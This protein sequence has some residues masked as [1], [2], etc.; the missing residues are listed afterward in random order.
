[1]SE[2]DKTNLYFIK[3]YDWFIN[4]DEIR[5]IESQEHGA[6]VVLM[7]FRLMIIA[8]N[9]NGKIARI[10]GK[11]ETPYTI[12]EMASV[13]FKTEEQLLNGLEI[14]KKAE[15]VFKEDDYYVIPKALE[16]TNQTTIG[17]KKKQKQR[18]DKE[19]KEEDNCP[20]EIEEEKDKEIRKKN[21]EA[22]TYTDKEKEIVSEVIKHLN[23]VTGSSYR[24]DSIKTIKLICNWL[25]KDF[26][27]NDF[28]EVI[29]KKNQEW[30]GTEREKYIRP[31][32]LFGDK[33]ENYV[34]QK[35][36]RKAFDNINF[37]SLYANFD[38]GE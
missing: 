17:A 14:L 31:E 24:I 33:F 1:M 13:T 3:L 2:Y 28:I 8:K 22:E 11:M 6:E 38:V 30:R 36:D 32:T 23:N 19:D 37:N 7:F 34:N 9:K 20:P 18:K 12:K 27:K 10:V 35:Y 16:F 26:K 5:W 29:D 4:S 25:A 15:L 21:K